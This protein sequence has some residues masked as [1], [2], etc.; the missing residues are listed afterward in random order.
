MYLS[1]KKKVWGECGG[2]QGREVLVLPEYSLYIFNAAQ[3]QTLHMY[4]AVILFCWRQKSP[5]KTTWPSRDFV[6]IIQY[7]NQLSRFAQKCPTSFWAEMTKINVS[8]FWAR[9]EYH[10]YG[11]IHSHHTAKAPWTN[12][13]LGGKSWFW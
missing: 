10:N 4:V 2:I 13:F 5:L 12:S 8:Y 6:L 11:Y 7:E 3:S 1:A 9:H